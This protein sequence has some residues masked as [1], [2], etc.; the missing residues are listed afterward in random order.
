MYKYTRKS[1]VFLFKKVYS[2][3]TSA[4]SSFQLN[5]SF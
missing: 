3:L 5:R 2:L 1:K 4:S